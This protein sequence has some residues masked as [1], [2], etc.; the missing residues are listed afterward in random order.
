MGDQ[1]ETDIFHWANGVDAH[2]DELDIDLFLFTKGYTVYSTSFSK[3]LKAQLK[4]IFLYDLIS[5]VQTGAATGMAV[6]EFEKSEGED[7]VLEFTTL[8]KVEHAQEVIEQ[9]L[10]GEEALEI[11]TDG[12]HELRKIKGIIARF[13]VKG[14]EPFFV[15]K[16]LQQ[17][18]ILRGVQSWTFTEKGQFKPMAESAT[19]RVTP[20][21]QI[22]VIG[23]HIFAF[24]E[25]KFVRLFGYDARTFATIDNKIA[26]IEKHFTLKYPDGVTFAALAR[27]NATLARKLSK[28]DPKS[29]TQDALI[30]HSDEFD[31]ALMTD[32]AAR[33][34]IIMAAKDALKFVNLLN[35]DYVESDMTG[36]KYLVGNKKLLSETGDNQTSLDTR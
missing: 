13:R 11:F 8:E 4:V 25:T 35:D 33:A 27:E 32:D 31:I 15:V 1:Q 3:N 6:K 16:L 17:S 34:I 12:E 26:D 9:I 19:I 10:Y 29:V 36:E 7:N 23:D 14:Q 20:D 24:N 28:V 30:E 5:T 18:Q 21:N 22:L 2:K